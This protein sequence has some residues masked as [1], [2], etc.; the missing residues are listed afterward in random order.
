MHTS[1]PSPCRAGWLLTRAGCPQVLSSAHNQA[2]RKCPCTQ[3]LSSIEVPHS[4][5]VQVAAHFGARGSGS[6]SGY[7]L[8][9]PTTHARPRP[10]GRRGCS[11]EDAVHQRQ[12]TRWGVHRV[13]RSQDSACGRGC[14]QATQP[15]QQRLTAAAKLHRACKPTPVL[16]AGA[17]CRV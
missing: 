14:T 15:A 1:L 12:H 4:L 16:H 2:V 13:W 5:P 10:R 8:A 17:P 7:A 9:F 11:R 3:W 6:Q